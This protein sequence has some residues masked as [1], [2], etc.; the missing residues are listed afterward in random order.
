MQLASLPD[1]K[2]LTVALYA[3]DS[4]AGANAVKLGE[5]VFTASG[6][7]TKVLAIVSARVTGDRG[8]Y[9]AVKFQHDA[10]AGVIC[11]VT[12]HGRAKNRPPDNERVLCL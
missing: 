1:T 6:A 5:E 2:S 11:S 12:A 4:A 3:A 7:Q 10:G 8:A 9:Y